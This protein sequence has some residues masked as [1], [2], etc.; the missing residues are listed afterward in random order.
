MTT[1]LY[2]PS[3]A[4]MPWLTHQDSI[5][6]K[7][8]TI[9]RDVR[10]DVLRHEW[11]IPDTW[12]TEVLKISTPEHVL[13]REILMWASTDICWYARTI[14]PFQTYYAEKSRFS[15]LKTQALGELIWHD[16]NIKRV[17]MEHYPIHPDNIE[18]QF[19]THTMHRNERPLW[20]RLSTISIHDTL[21][22]YLL[23][24]FLPD[25]QKYCI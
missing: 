1:G 24:I 12:D 8:K 14:L 17:K 5:T 16:P 20:A 15:R 7:L 25:L 21:P 22:L 13:H 2:K 4:L 3:R 19:L 10:L 6:D 18:Y 11:G 9:A 23:E